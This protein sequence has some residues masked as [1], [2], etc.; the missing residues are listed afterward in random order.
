V[1]QHAPL[2][3]PG[4]VVEVLGPPM[5]LLSAVALN[6]DCCGCGTWVC[7]LHTQ[8]AGAVGMMPHEGWV[9]FPYTAYLIPVQV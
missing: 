1:L 8:V 3:F 2:S 5:G 6:C 7:M 4:P 9:G